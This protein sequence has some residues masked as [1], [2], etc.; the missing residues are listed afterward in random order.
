MEDK[1]T[2]WIK[3]DQLDTNK[4]F[5]YII[6]ECQIEEGKTCNYLIDISGEDNMVFNSP[7]FNYNFYVNK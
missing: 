7:N 5:V 3:K 2:T 4:E 1:V 6:V